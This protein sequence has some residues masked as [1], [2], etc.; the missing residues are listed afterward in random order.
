M[1]AK[2]RNHI[3]SFA[4]LLLNRV[5]NNIVNNKDT[6]SIQKLITTFLFL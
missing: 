2:L 6:I 1:G 5:Y 3:C 4:D